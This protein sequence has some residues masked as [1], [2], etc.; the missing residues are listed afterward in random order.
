MELKQVIVR[1]NELYHKSKLVSL[2]STELEERDS[3]RRIYLDSIKQQFKAT[4]DRI[5]V[6]D[7]EEETCGS[8]KCDCNCGCGHH[9]H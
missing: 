7:Q 9:H 2:T 8:G 5:E 6:V 3:L 1:L 4:L